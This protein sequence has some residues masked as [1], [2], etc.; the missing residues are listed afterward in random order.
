MT[1]EIGSLDGGSTP[2]ASTKSTF[3][4]CITCGKKFRVIIDH[5]SVVHCSKECVVDGGVLDS[6]GNRRHVEDRQS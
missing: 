2:P 3:R 4:N 5:P 6:T 1:H